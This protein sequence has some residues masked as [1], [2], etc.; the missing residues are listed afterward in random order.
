MLRRKI[1]IMMRNCSFL[2]AFNGLQKPFEAGN[3][4]RSHVFIFEKK[5][6][7]LYGYKEIEED[8]HHFSINSFELFLLGVIWNE[9]IYFPISLNIS[10]SMQKSLVDAKYLANKLL[11]YLANKLIHF[12]DSLIWV[13]FRNNHFFLL[14]LLPFNDLKA[15]GIWSFLV[16][17]I[18]E[19]TMV[20]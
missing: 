6:P 7:I 4:R 8:I 16:R 20:I 9:D 5:N 15:T 14:L 19:T 3:H 18:L 17:F 11:Q 2:L 13:T 1:I 10:W 12:S